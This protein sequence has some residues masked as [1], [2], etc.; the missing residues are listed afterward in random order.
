MKLKPYFYF[1]LL[2]LLLNSCIDDTV[3]V[4]FPEGAVEGYKPIYSEVSD[5]YVVKSEAVHPME[6]V[7]KIILVGTTLFVNERFEGIH[8]IDNANPA[9]PKQIGFIRISGNT[10]LS[11]KGDYIY[12]NNYEDLVTILVTNTGEA[13][14]TDRKSNVFPELNPSSGLI[15]TIPFGSYFE[16]VDQAKGT[17]LRWEKTSITNPQCRR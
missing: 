15:N 5:P 17:V 12:A 13:T 6:N 7:G 16:C 3:V 8:I 2:G 1:L 4:E 9:E 11:K 14:V 10:E